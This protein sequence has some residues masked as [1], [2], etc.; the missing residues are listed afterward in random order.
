[1]EREKNWIWKN[2]KCHLKQNRE[3]VPNHILFS[4]DY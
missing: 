4:N 2:V 1:M 3:L